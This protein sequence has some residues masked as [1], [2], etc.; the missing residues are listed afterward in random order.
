VGW[1]KPWK[2]GTET[3]RNKNRRSANEKDF[4]DSN[5]FGDA[6]GMHCCVTGDGEGKEKPCSGQIMYFVL[7]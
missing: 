7:V 6:G 3:I 1:C 2:P 5:N 4:T